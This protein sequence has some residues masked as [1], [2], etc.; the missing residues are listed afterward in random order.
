MEV[1]VQERP[2][3]TNV[4]VHSAVSEPFQH[5][6]TNVEKPGRFFHPLLGTLVTGAARLML[7]ITERLI[8]EHELEW[9]FCDTDSMSIARPPDM[10]RSTFNERVDAIVSWFGNLNPYAFGGSIL[11]VEDY[12]FGLSA[13]QEREPLYCWCVSAKR[14]A[15]FNLGTD[16]QP[17]IRKASAHGLGHFIAPYNEKSPAQGIPA[18]RAKLAKIGVV[19]WQHDLWYR[20]AS[21]ALAGKPDTVDLSYHAALQLP[22]VSRYSASTPKLLAWFADVNAGRPYREQV[23]PGNFLYSC[24]VK[25]FAGA[26]GVG[27]AKSRRSKADVV[28]PVAPYDKDLSTALRSAFDRM[29]GNPVK[30][31]MLA[32]YAEQLAQYH[33]QPE[34][35]FLNGDYLDRGTTIRR[36]VI[37]AGIELIGKEANRWEEQEHLGATEDAEISYGMVSASNAQLANQV[38]ALT[39]IL[40]QRE[41]AHRLGWSRGRLARLIRCQAIKLPRSELDRVRRELAEI[42]HET[43]ELATKRDAARA[44]IV[45]MIAREG[46]PATSK[47]LGVDASNLS[48]IE[49]GKRPPSALILAR[50]RGAVMSSELLSNLSG[51]SS[52]GRLYPLDGNPERV[53]HARLKFFEWIPLVALYRHPGA[54][55]LRGDLRSRCDPSAEPA[56]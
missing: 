41:F 45:E 25:R 48:K 16:G 51:A 49:R 33:L 24:F 10:E 26:Q 19:L 27:D 4:N 39:A 54:A 11:K 6:T 56:H 32:T 2:D 47:I 7:V 40:G 14:Y 42:R 22:A 44:G 36:H 3:P 20:I 43:D 18:P 8:A 46:R 29:T 1:N 52:R 15:L 30:L 9:A 34:S 50:F 17:I 31:E 21:A 12:N 37:V 28:R 35:K 13:P 55:R 5:P 53:R 23:K 38:R